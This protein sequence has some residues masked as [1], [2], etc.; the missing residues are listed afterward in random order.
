MPLPGKRGTQGDENKG[1]NRDRPGSRGFCVQFTPMVFDGRAWVRISTP[2]PN[3]RAAC[4]NVTAYISLL[5][6]SASLSDL[7]AAAEAAIHALE[8][9]AWTVT[10][11]DEWHRV[12]RAD[13]CQARDSRR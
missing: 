10:V 6:P 4:L 11:I 1:G 3:A 13:L 5:S 8:E 2:Q 12:D 9:G 7:D